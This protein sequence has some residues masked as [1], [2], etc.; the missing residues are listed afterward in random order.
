MLQRKEGRFGGTLGRSTGWIH[1][2][3]LARHGVEMIAG[4][5][6]RRIDDDG[7]HVTVADEERCI[8]AD[9]VVIC[10]GQEPLD[11]LAA[12]LPADGPPVHRIGGAREAVELDA[13]R[14]IR[15]GFELALSF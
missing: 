11:A 1:R 4:A 12:A 15:E 9:T 5:T 8:P 13:V 3:V 2:T 7:L 14:A 10:A 6:Y